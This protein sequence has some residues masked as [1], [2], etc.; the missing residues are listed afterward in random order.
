MTSKQRHVYGDPRVETMPVLA[1]TVLEIGDMCWF[2]STNNCVK[3]A[4]DYTWDTDLA[5]TQGTFK[6]V[7]CG[8]ARTAK[9]ST[10]P[11]GSAQV[12]T[13][14]VFRFDCAS[15]AFDLGVFIGPAKASGNALENQ[16][17]VAVANATLAIGKPARQYTSAV[18]EIYVRAQS[19]IHD[20]AGGVQTIT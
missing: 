19:V 9:R 18:T 13:A 7:F 10:D 15:A 20:T 16:K 14:G 6:D 4:S 11:A 12:D 1:A 8:V 2:D 3:P 17:V 5:T